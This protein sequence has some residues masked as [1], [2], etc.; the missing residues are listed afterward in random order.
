MRTAREVATAVQRTIRKRK[1]LR[2]HFEV[3]E[4][5]D[6]T[7]AEPELLKRMFGAID[8]KSGQK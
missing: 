5:E 1:E 3:A 7:A 4:L 2:E 8:P 6:L